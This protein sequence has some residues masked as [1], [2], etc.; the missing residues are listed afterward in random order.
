M[1]AAATG[2]QD[3]QDAA[4]RLFGTIECTPADSIFADKD[5]NVDDANTQKVFVGAVLAERFQIVRY[6]ESGAFGRGWVGTDTKGADPEKRIFIKTFRSASDRPSPTDAKAHEHMVKKEIDVLLQADCT[7]LPPHPN[8]VSFTE[9]H[10]GSVLVPATGHTGNMFFLVSQDL[11]EGGELYNYLVFGSGIKKFEETIARYFFKQLCEGVAHMHKNGIFHRDLKLENIVLDAH[12]VAKIM[13]FGHAKHAAECNTSVDASGAVQYE[14]STFVGTSSYQPPEL[15]KGHGY[16]P[17]A[18]DVWSLGVI[19]FFMVGIEGLA[20]SN[21][22]FSFIAKVKAARSTHNRKYDL[23]DQ[24]RGKDGVPAN[25]RFWEFFGRHLGFS[26]ELKHLINAMFDQNDHTRWK[27]EQVLQHPW[28]KGEMPT[29][30][31]VVTALAGRHAGIVERDLVFSLAEKHPTQAAAFEAIQKA[32]KQIA[33]FKIYGH[34]IGVCD[35]PQFAIAVNES[36]KVRV[37]W[38]LGGL[39]EWLE[40]RGLL[41][42]NLGIAANKV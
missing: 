7:K 19:L 39:A 9:V 36:C 21:N 30:E 4:R 29:H 33:P 22:D 32:L 17:A 15:T 42:K 26:P 16:N 35:P 8:I 1:A 10:Y 18:F 34:K 11:C 23:L 5:G 41:F 37:M 31:Q 24:S 28:L 40:F 20:A 14:T 6:I 25:S 12:Y 13:D 2:A 38:L 3:S 27:I